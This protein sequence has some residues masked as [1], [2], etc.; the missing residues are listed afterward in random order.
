MKRPLAG[1]PLRVQLSLLIVLLLSAGLLL[2]S[3]LATA[4]LSGYLHGRVDDQ[5]ARNARPFASFSGQIPGPTDP[6]R[7]QPRLPSLGYAEIRTPEGA[8][9]MDTPDGASG[10]APSL[11]DDLTTLVGTPFTTGSGEGGDEWRVLVT[12]L[13]SED[14][15]GVVAISLGDVRATVGRLMLLQLAVGLAVVATAGIIGFLLV[16]R[17]LRPLD[18]MALTAHDIAE[19][20]LTRR[21]AQA[22][23]SAEVDELA[24]SFNAMVTRIE[25]SFAAQ[26]ASEVQ[27]RQS[28]ER[29][30]RF[31]ADAGHELRT[32]LT[33]IRGYAELIEQGAASDPTDAVRRIQDEAARMGGLVEDLQLL[34][35]LDEHRPLRQDDVDLPA[36][37]ADSVEGARVADPHRPISLEVDGEP[38][39]VSGDE[40]RLR[41]VLDNLLSNALR[42]SPPGSPVSVRVGTAGGE[43]QALR[44]EVSDQG[45]GLTSDEADRVFDRL[46]RTDDARSRVDGGGG[47]GLA[48][49]QSIVE[50]HGGDA[51]VRSE[52]GAGSTFGFTLPSTPTRPEWS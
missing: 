17:S 28:E 37:A 2:S 3:L 23:T 19:G 11:P 32:P 33:S 31:V 25:A 22:P 50:A 24:S 43:H 47:L 1:R 7:P 45:S 10:I 36:L 5:L 41:Q 6:T 26:Q 35:R 44:V 34:A 49:V 51:Y 46:Y 9:V 52:V 21:V 40:G 15:F 18:D 38:G 13:S 16:R 39:R 27:A 29:M 48:I 20:D 42:Y 30:R 8:R 12:P 14:G 4:A